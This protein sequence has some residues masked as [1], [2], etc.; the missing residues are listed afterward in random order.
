MG[1]RSGVAGR[2]ARGHSAP[3][4]RTKESKMKRMSSRHARRF[5]LI[6]LLVLLAGVAVSGLVI[7]T[8]SALALP[9]PITAEERQI[10]LAVQQLMR[11][12][13]SGHPL[14]DEMSRRCMDTFL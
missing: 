2:E 9:G 6:G 11:F 10:V 3:R 5:S 8:P 14:D 1:L 13:L 4:N 12:H 7:C